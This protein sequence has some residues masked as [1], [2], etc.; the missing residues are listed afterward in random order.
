VGEVVPTFNR[1]L[2]VRPRKTTAYT[3]TATDAHG[4]QLQRT[5]VLY[6]VPAT[7][8]GRPTRKAR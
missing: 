8:A 7:A 5:T 1:C 3:L 4:T 6:V 2:E